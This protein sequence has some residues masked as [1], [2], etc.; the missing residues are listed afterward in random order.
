[1]YIFLTFVHLLGVCDT[2][3][4]LSVYVSLTSVLLPLLPL[5]FISCNNFSHLLAFQHHM[6]NY[7]IISFCHLCLFE[8]SK[9]TTA[10]G[11]EEQT[12]GMA[13]P[14]PDFSRATNRWGMN[15]LSRC[16]HRVLCSAQPRSP[17][18]EP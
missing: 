17:T 8:S 16:G 1:M 3:S 15:H 11:A 7:K 18:W 14:L 4:P 10:L 13:V 2:S 6:I 9:V 12:R 5:Y